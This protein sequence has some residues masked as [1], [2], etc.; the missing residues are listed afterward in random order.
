M[1]G[2]NGCGANGS[3]ECAPDDKLRDT[4]QLHLMGMTGFAGS[5]HPTCW[6]IAIADAPVGVYEAPLDGGHD[7]PRT[8]ISG[9]WTPPASQYFLACALFGL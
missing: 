8:T 7:G 2:A 3:R 5:T 6:G 9:V 1:G 4:H